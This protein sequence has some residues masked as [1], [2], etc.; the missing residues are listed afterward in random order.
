MV[1]LDDATIDLLL[2]HLG[3]L[4]SPECEFFIAHLGGAVNRVSP[5]ATAYPHR[6]IEFVVNIHTR[7][8]DVSQDQ[9]CIGWARELFDRL[10]PHA[11]GAVYVNF[12]SEDEAQRVSRGAY[13][14]NYQRLAQLKARYDPT[15]LFRRNRNIVPA[16]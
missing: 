6:D 13:G 8:G 2:A 10:A 9:A 4:P 11:T 3:H 5:T 7:W 12:M 15:N 14:G 16:R 1:D